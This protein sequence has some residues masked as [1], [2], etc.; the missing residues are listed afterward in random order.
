MAPTILDGDSGEFQYMVYSLGVPH[1]PG[2]PLYILIGKLF[3]F[4]PI[5]DIAFRV[6]LFSAVTAATAAAFIYWTIRRVTSR[7]LSAFLATALLVVSPSM[8]GSAVRAETYALHLLLGVVTIFFA[9][10]WHQDGKRRDLYALAFVCGLGLLN[11]PIYRFLAPGLVVMLWLNR[12]RLDR[13]MIAA[14][15]LLVVLPVV[16][17]AYV[18]LRAEQLIALQDPENLKLYSRP[19]AIVKGIVTAYYNHSLEGFVYLVS[20]FD[21]RGKLELKSLDLLSRLPLS[22][23]LLFQQFGV[24]GLFFVGLG[25]WSSIR[26]ERGLWIFLFVCAAG[27]GGAAFILKGISTVYYFSL[28]YVILTVWIGQGLDSFVAWAERIG[29]ASGRAAVRLLAS[30]PI[31]A[32]FL[33]ILPLSGLSANYANQDLSGNNQYRELAQDLLKQPFPE[34][35]VLNAPWEISEPLR[36]LQ[37]AENVRPDLL[38]MNVPADW[39]QFSEILANANKNKRPFFEVEFNPILKTDPGPRILQAI[40]LPMQAVPRP[41]HLLSETRIVPQVQVIGYD[42]EPEIPTPGAPTRLW[43]YYRATE[44]MYPMYSATL[45]VSDIRGRP[46]NDI[47]G[48]PVSFQFPT[49][50]WYE[51]GEYY[52]DGWTLSLPPDAPIGLYNLDLSWQ[53]YDLD[54]RRPNYD[55]ASQISLGTIRIG[56]VTSEAIRNHIDAMFGDSI[57]LRGWDSKPTDVDESISVR[58]D[59]TLD[60]TLFWRAEQP[61]TEALTIFV[62]LIDMNG[63]VLATGDS[64]PLQGMY[65]TDRWQVGETV[66]DVH[67]LKIPPTL[68]SGEYAI[69]VGMYIPASGARLKLSGSSTNSDALIL[70]KV[71]LR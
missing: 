21:N 11:H 47:L 39:D 50:R 34:K 45:S 61:L 70:A 40:P 67:P 54:T 48:F 12:F 23:A 69:E 30:Q 16:L 14:G 71:I 26:R 28:T 6:N 35:A 43:I 32:F 49:Y 36:Y 9:L 25:I 13:R 4:I 17:Y 44:R 56:K 1:S 38:V 59:Q 55:R 53:V 51:L 19:D 18:P 60:L 2:Y 5:A 66:S 33:L 10:R 20:G 22:A 65:P 37:F 46:W 62:H 58:R 7:R 52:R 68:V 31:T 64:P 63:R 24:S 57:T 3:T 8:W 41:Q 42:L 29:A 27:V 15:V